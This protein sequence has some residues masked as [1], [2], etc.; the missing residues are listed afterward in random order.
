MKAETIR[1]LPVWKFFL[2]SVIT[3]LL[4]PLL[5]LSLAGDGCWVEGWIFSLWFDGMVLSN[6][7]Y[8]YFNNP[9]L[10]ADRASL[11]GSANQKKWD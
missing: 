9:E 11:P 10:L 5:I 1:T 2:Y 8:L 4:P 3:A 7:I 6:S